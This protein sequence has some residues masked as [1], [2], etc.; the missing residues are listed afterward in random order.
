MGNMNSMSA[1]RFVYPSTAFLKGV[2]VSRR[3]LRFIAEDV[4]GA[5]LSDRMIREHG[6]Q[7]F[8]IYDATQWA[9]AKAQVSEWTQLPLKL[10]RLHTLMWGYK[11]SSTLGGLAWK[12]GIASKAF[13][14][15]IAAYNEAIAG[16]RSD[17][18]QKDPEH[19][20]PIQN[21]PF[22]GVDISATRTG[23]QVVNSLTLGGPRVSGQTGQVLREDGLSIEGLY[24]AGTTVVGICSNSY[25]SGLSIANAVFSGIRAGTHGAKVALVHDQTT[26]SGVVNTSKTPDPRM[27]FFIY[28]QMILSRLERYLVII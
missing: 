10:Q 8:A 19:C 21:G 25:V 9:R 23:P 14:Q 5:T 24:A 7:G 28:P 26:N 12:L 22:N 13:A 17:P 18:L 15:T 6:N 3:G 20:T 27:D 4:Y 2:L 1:W 16:G 11:K